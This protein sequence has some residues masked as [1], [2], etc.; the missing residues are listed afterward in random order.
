MSKAYDE[1]DQHAS[2]PP[3]AREIHRLRPGDLCL[4]RLL[5]PDA[6]IASSPQLKTETEPDQGSG[7]T[8]PPGPVKGTLQMIAW[9]EASAV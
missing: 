1:S 9:P 2:Q 4:A 6:P 3:V 7:D 8:E 5:P